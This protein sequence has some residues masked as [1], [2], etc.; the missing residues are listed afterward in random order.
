MLLTTT[1]PFGIVMAADTRLTWST[2]RVEDNRRKI[3]PWDGMRAAVGFAGLATL[4]G[5]F[6]DEIIERV[7][8]DRH[9]NTLDEFAIALGPELRGRIPAHVTSEDRRIYVHIAGFGPAGELARAQFHYVR[10]SEWEVVLDY[11]QVNEDLRDTFLAQQGIMTAADLSEGDFF[12]VQ[13]S[14]VRPVFARRVQRNL[15]RE[16]QHL[17]DLDDIVNW[18]KGQIRG[19]ALDL[20][21]GGHA[22]VVGEAALV[23]KI[24]PAGVERC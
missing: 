1:S 12:R 3:V 2:G 19:V 17:H 22:P 23:Y 9:W 7:T 4:N 15:A 20:Q 5:G 10:N 13:F 16:V 14:G 11:F 18:A 24:A 21:R 6:T 8:T